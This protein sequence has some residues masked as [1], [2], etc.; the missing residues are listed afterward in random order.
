MAPESCPLFSRGFNTFPK[1]C[2]SEC[3]GDWPEPHLELEALTITTQ[4]AGPQ[5][6][7][8]S[9]SACPEPLLRKKL[10]I[11]GSPEGKV[12]G[13]SE[14]VLVVQTSPIL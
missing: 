3:P 13:Q 5:P 10:L 7:A 6:E 12:H 11:L 4:G 2:S 1:T 14:K 9:S 8:C